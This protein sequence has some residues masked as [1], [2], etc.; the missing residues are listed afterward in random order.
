MNKIQLNKLTSGEILVVGDVMLDQYWHGKTN[1][2]SPEAP[3]PVVKVD[4]LQ[5]FPGGAGNVALNLAALGVTVR[6]FG[7]SGNDERAE[8]LSSLL[9]Q[10]QVSNHIQKV[11]NY[12]TINKL[13]VLSQHQ[14]L[15]RLDFEESFAQFDKTELFTQF[16]AHLAT[17]QAV[18][19]SDYAKGCLTE[20]QKFIQAARDKQIPVII[21]PKRDDFAAYRG[22]TILTPNIHEFERVVGNC[23]TQEVLEDKARALLQ[24]HDLQALLVTQGANGMSLIQLD[25]PVLHI[26]ARSHEVY[27]VT[28]AGD[29]VVA[30]L[31]Y[32]LACQVPFAAASQLANIAAGLVVERL[33]AASVSLPELEAAIDEQVIDNKALIYSEADLQN[34]LNIVALKRACNEQIALIIGNFD[35]L[36][37][38]HL[39]I[40]SNVKQNNNFV[41]VALISDSIDGNKLVNSVA[42]RCQVVLELSCVDQVIIMKSNELDMMV[43]KVNPDTILYE[44]SIENIELV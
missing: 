29:T 44:S 37:E 39:E 23:E 15:L 12:P 20:P 18:I 42:E 34:L 40:F 36:N 2:I 5:S 26:P 11:A 41:I 27:D 3:V 9:E 13:R 17:A 7:L 43:E 30:L 19:L 25:Q 31:S 10:A 16:S 4:E 22:A 28:G 24:Q 21:D 35:I 14:Q 1:R 33:G 32:A 6:L 38:H 8:L